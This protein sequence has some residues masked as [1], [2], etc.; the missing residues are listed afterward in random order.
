MKTLLDL[1][2]DAYMRGD[3]E[4]SN[5]LSDAHVNEDLVDEFDELLESAKRES[6]AQG[7]ADGLEESSDVDLLEKIADLEKKVAKYE[8]AYTRELGGLRVVQKWFDSVEIKT[9]AGRKFLA[10]KLKDHLN[11]SAV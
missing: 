5:I 6:Y 11:C 10:Q 9:V 7:R 8:K 1:S 3:T 2:R 4:L